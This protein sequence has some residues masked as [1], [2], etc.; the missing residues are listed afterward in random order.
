ML[1]PIQ[2]LVRIVTGLL[3]P[4]PYE[5]VVSARTNKLH[6]ERA[7]TLLVR[8]F[9]TL[10]APLLAEAL[11]AVVAHARTVTSSTA[12]PPAVSQCVSGFQLV[13]SGI[14]SGRPEVSEV[15][16]HA[17]ACGNASRGP[18]GSISNQPCKPERVP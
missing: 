18:H 1:S 6:V 3:R 8:V 17:G 14:A 16:A 5:H 9:T 12:T 15:I 11:I 2:L 4:N 7:E 10:D 13:D